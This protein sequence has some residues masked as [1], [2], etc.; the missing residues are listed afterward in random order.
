M[1]EHN[2]VGWY[3]TYLDIKLSPK[4][5]LN[6]EYQWRRDDVLIRPKQYVGNVGANYKIKRN[7]TFRLGFVY[8]ETDNYGKEPVQ[9]FGKKFPEY[10]TYQMLELEN[11]FSSFDLTHR[12]MLDQRWVGEFDNPNSQSIDDFEYTNRIR[13]ML[14][15]QRPILLLDIDKSI[16]F[17]IYNEI[18]LGFGKNIGD[19]LFD[20]NRFGV[21][22]G[23]KI[24]DLLR[25]DG[26][27][28]YQ[29]GKFGRMVNDSKYFQ[30][31]SGLTINTYFNL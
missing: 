23:Y 18:L 10:R 21:L 27:Y 15:F 20:Q 25:L 26:G 8:S 11:D 9:E 14:R 1:H 29:M 2:F 30:H 16:Y 31:N 22:I 5:S 12:L 19:D 13:Y 17:A 24:S 3:A 6:G 28:F 7:L 4:W